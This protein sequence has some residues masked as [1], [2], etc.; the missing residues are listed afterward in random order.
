M[1]FASQAPAAIANARSHRNGRE[2]FEAPGHI[3]RRGR[4]ALKILLPARELTDGVVA[5][6][7]R[8]VLGPAPP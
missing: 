1:L 7:H 4:R 8:V 2:S 3:I 5:H 6:E